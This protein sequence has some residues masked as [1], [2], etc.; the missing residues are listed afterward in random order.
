MNNVHN[1]FTKLCRDEPKITL[2]TDSSKS[3][4]GAVLDSFKTRGSWSLED[5]QLHINVLEMKAVLFGLQSL[6]NKY[7][8]SHILIKTDSYTGVCYINSKGGLKSDGCNA[9]ALEIWKWAIMRNNFLSAVHVPG[10]LNYLADFESR[11]QDNNT[12]WS[13]ND[14]IYNKITEIFI[15]PTIDLFASY[16]NY[17]VDKY[18]SWMPDPKAFATNTFHNN[19]SNEIF[20][21]F[22]P[23]SLLNRFLQK[24]EME[25]MEGILIAPAWSTQ[26]FFPILHRLLIQIPIQIRWKKDILSH[27]NKNMPHPL[28]RKIK[29]T[30]FRL[31]TNLIK[32]KV[33]LKELYK[34]L[35]KDGGNLLPNNIKFTLTD[36]NIIVNNSIWIPFL[37][38]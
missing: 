8:N 2:F 26:P 33:F 25:N 5:Q 23:F 34:L 1:E 35:W 9:M 30:A 13:L 14:V 28:G 6:C 22:P 16:L 18:V 29:L 36:G 31:S 38:I 27:P 3:G 15:K 19:F 21:A 32:R 7:V 11:K 17:K 20:Y 10:K 37:A 4:W 24:V 12:E